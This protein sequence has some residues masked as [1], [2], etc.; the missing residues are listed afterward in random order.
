MEKREI[1]EINKI[2]ELF[3]IEFGIF[4]IKVSP[5]KEIFFLDLDFISIFAPEMGSSQ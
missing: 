5:K 3:F 1:D 2:F 4:A